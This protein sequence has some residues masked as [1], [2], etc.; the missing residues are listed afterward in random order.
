MKRVLAWDKAQEIAFECEPGTITEG[1]LEIL[2]GM[3]VTRLSL[4]IENFDEA[5]LRANGRAHGAKEI[6]RAYS[7]PDRSVSLRS[8]SI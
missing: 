6:D 1:K 5:I 3:G 4:G 2:K 7:S 8:T